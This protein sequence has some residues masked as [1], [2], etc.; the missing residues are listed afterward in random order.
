MLMVTIGAYL[1]KFRVC[2]QEERVSLVKWNFLKHLIDSNRLDVVRFYDIQNIL[3][4]R[5]Y[6]SKSF[7]T[8]VLRQ[9]Y[10]KL[11]YFSVIVEP[12]LKKF[13]FGFKVFWK[14]LIKTVVIRRFQNCIRLAI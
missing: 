12:Y 6:L 13:S 5:K 9:F 7:V 14:W 1:E 3:F 11:N 10:P 2:Y 4:S 8:I